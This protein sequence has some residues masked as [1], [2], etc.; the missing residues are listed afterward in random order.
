MAFEWCTLYV[1]EST[2]TMVKISLLQLKSEL[3]I[4]IFAICIGAMSAS[5]GWAKLHGN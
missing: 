4:S 1:P 3:I 5:P 2:A